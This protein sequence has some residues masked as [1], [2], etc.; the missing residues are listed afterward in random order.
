MKASGNVDG[1]LKKFLWEGSKEAKRIPLINWDTACLIQEEGRAS[2]R[3]LELQNKALGAKLAWKIFKNPN[4]LWYRVIRYKYLD[5][6]EEE[7]IF[8]TENL[9][10][11]SPVWNFIWDSRSL[12]TD[13]L[14]WNIGNGRKAKF[15]S[16]SWGGEKPLKK[17]FEDQDWINLVEASIGCRVMDYFTPGGSIGERVEWK[18]CSIGNRDL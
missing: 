1:L 6:L 3:K 7:R 2:L 18:K 17:I 8:T 16:D 13:H 4:R 5:S 15:W 12:L 10:K 14:S 9:E 11:G